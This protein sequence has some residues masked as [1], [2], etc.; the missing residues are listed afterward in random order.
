MGVN[1]VSAWW[2]ALVGTLAGVVGATTAIIQVMQSRNNRQISSASSG[3][4]STSRVR[5]RPRADPPHGMY[6]MPQKRFSNLSDMLMG[7]LKLSLA[8]AFIELV[9]WI[10]MA[11]L[12]VL[13]NARPVLYTIPIFLASVTV[14]GIFFDLFLTV[15]SDDAWGLANTCMAAAILI[16]DLAIIVSS[17]KISSAKS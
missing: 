4:A 11:I 17:I 14:L 3:G 12:P 13:P 7:I 5:R 9:A 6:P 16:I 1:G 15:F 8:T 2:I 10:V